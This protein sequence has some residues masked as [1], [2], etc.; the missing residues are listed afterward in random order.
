MVTPGPAGRTVCPGPWAICPDPGAFPPFHQ[1]FRRQ[2]QRLAPKRRMTPLSLWR[3]PP[4]GGKA[5]PRLRKARL[6][7]RTAPPRDGRLAPKGGTAPG[8]RGT[9]PLSG[10]IVHSSGRITYVRIEDTCAATKTSCVLD[11]YAPEPQANAY[12]G[13]PVIDSKPCSIPEGPA[14]CGE[15][16]LTTEKGRRP[17][18]PRTPLARQGGSAIREGAG[19]H[20]H[21]I[22]RRG[23]SGTLR[24]RVGP[25]CLETSPSP[26]IFYASLGCTL[27]TTISVLEKSLP[28][29][30]SASPEKRERA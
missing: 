23:R 24:Q 3:T 19:R 17:P 13:G 21:G 25:L 18:C 2:R 8:L 11:M 10:G 22:R 12:C 5:R 1:A 26:P 16:S 27:A 6:L 28:L 20:W 29:K 4:E 15:R 9:V 7:R 30:R 14:L